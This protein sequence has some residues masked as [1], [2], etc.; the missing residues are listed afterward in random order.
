MSEYRK[1]NGNWE[2]S[3]NDNILAKKNICEEKSHTY[4]ISLLS[5]SPGNSN[6]ESIK[7]FLLQTRYLFKNSFYTNWHIWESGGAKAL[8]CFKR[9]NTSITPQMSGGMRVR[10]W[11][12][13]IYS[14]TW[15][16]ET[17]TCCIT[18]Y[19]RDI[20]MWIDAKHLLFQVQW[21]RDVSISPKYKE[22]MLKEVWCVEPLTSNLKLIQ[23][24]GGGHYKKCYNIFVLH[25][26]I[27]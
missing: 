12:H 6:V 13:V 14:T 25:L 18:W 1:K 22:I 3:V 5:L 2:I 19:T 15:I 21:L 8:K 7:T 23:A 4:S 17:R 16:I 27:F 24:M 26:Q 11:R 10:N 20:H 9:Q